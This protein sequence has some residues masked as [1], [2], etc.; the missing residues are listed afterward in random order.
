MD[1]LEYYYF[2]TPNKPMDLNNGES[3][4]F[5]NT[6]THTHTYTHTHA[7]T[8]THTRTHSHTHTHARYAY[9]KQRLLH[10]PTI[11]Y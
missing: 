9:G 8:H 2:A 3:T 11:I 1:E 4:A 6:H 5:V 10:T 7:H